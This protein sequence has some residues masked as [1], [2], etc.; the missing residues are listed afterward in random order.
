MKYFF[1]TFVSGYGFSAWSGYGSILLVNAL[2]CMTG[3]TYYQNHCDRYCLLNGQ[4]FL[5]VAPSKNMVHLF[6]LIILTV[7]DI[8]WFQVASFKQKHV[9]HPFSEFARNPQGMF[10]KNIYSWIH[11]AR[12]THLLSNRHAHDQLLALRGTP[13]WWSFSMVFKETTDSWY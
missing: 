2:L 1:G 13:R 8:N 12:I 4:L 11:D 7:I 3:F 10:L 9:K 5:F 6:I